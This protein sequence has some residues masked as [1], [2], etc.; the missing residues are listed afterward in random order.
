PDRVRRPGRGDRDRLEAPGRPARGDRSSATM[1]AVTADVPGVVAHAFKEEWG[2][3]VATLIRVAGDWDLAEECTQDAFALALQT[4]PRDGLPQRPGAWLMRTARN[5][6]VDVLR[7]E[8][9]GAAKLREVAALAGPDDGVDDG[10]L[11]DAAGSGLR[12]DRLRL[13]FT[14]CH[15]ALAFESQVA[16]TLRTLAG[17]S[18]AEIA[19]AFLV[20]EATMPPRLVRAQNKIRSAGSSYGIPD[21]HQLPERP[22]AVLGVLYLLFNEGYS[23]TAGAELMRHSL[24]GEAIRLARVLTQLMPDEP[25][26][27]GLL[28]L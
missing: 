14:C 13:M 17:L 5:R 9:V 2:Q 28:A 4:W 10:G 15:P 7:R 19:R 12:D 25:E 24:C 26:A 6:A 3:I 20:P 18:T 8:A 22:A 21:D 27:A 1:G 16:L 11:G 23:A